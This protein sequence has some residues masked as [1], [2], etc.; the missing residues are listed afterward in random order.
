LDRY[1]QAALLNETETRA[2]ANVGLAT[3]RR[4]RFWRRIG[5]TASTSGIRISGG[6]RA[7]VGF[8]RLEP[9]CWPGWF[10]GSDHRISD[11]PT[12]VDPNPLWP[13]ARR[14]HPLDPIAT[15]LRSAI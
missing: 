11:D 7:V 2:A 4:T 9:A 13:V 3:R 5:G 1:H 14:V 10:G 8:S 15:S 6:L 12:R